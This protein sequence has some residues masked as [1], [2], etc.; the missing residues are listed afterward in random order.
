MFSVP[1]SASEA[2]SG[3]STSFL[4]KRE[5]R[6]TVRGF[7]GLLYLEMRPFMFTRKNWASAHQNPF[8]GLEGRPFPAQPKP[9]VSS[10]KA[11]DEAQ[12]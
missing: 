3:Y 8:N 5:C 2:P 9:R 4:V 1:L 10:G 11:S 6:S 7:E 12:R